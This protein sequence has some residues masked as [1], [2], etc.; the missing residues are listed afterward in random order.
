MKLNKEQT[1]AHVNWLKSSGGD[2][3]WEFLNE[4]IEGYKNDACRI[5]PNKGESYDEFVLNK[6]NAGAMKTA[7]EF[8]LAYREDMIASQK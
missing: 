6:N 4:L 1:E 2:F 5:R 8:S 7:I 3:Y